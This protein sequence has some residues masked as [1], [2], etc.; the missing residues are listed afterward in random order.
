MEALR[1]LAE[2]CSGRFMK[3]AVVKYVCNCFKN[4]VSVCC[5]IPKRKYMSSVRR[6]M[7]VPTPFMSCLVSLNGIHEWQ[8]SNN[9]K[10]RQNMLGR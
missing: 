2:A 3:D 6:F 8:E 10:L 5:N 7:A 4:V 9:R 1:L